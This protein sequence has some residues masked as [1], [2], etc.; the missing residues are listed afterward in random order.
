MPEYHRAVRQMRR[1][2]AASRI[3]WKPTLKLRTTEHLGVSAALLLDCSRVREES[4]LLQEHPTACFL[5]IF[6]PPLRLYARPKPA[7]Q[8]S[9]G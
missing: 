4:Q 3:I 9:D 5:S 7:I 1:S 2:C 8:A 6:S